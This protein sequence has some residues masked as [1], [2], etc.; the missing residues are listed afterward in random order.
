[1][2]KSIVDNPVLRK[3]RNDSIKELLPE[4]RKSLGKKYKVK[5][6]KKTGI[7]EISMRQK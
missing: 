1:M 7:V 2:K 6:I 3:V 5:W 4:L